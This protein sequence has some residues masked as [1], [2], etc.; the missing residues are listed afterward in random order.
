VTANVGGG[1]ERSLS[2]L[3]ATE[4]CR[5]LTGREVPIGSDPAN[6]PGDV[7]IYLSDCTRLEALTDWRPRR[8]PRRVM[9]DIQ[10]WISEHADQLSATLEFPTGSPAG[11]G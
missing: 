10:R 11:P 8:E 7:A 9:E 2:L 5:E 1:A 3:E 4:I 6:R